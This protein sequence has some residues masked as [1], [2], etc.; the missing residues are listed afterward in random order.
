MLNTCRVSS[1][2]IVTRRDAADIAQLRH[3]DCEKTLLRVSSDHDHCMLFAVIVGILRCWLSDSEVLE[4]RHDRWPLRALVP[5]S[6][7]DAKPGSRIWPMPSG[8]EAGVSK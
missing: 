6:E 7:G 1:A 5:K 3:D 2:L 8:I 4:T